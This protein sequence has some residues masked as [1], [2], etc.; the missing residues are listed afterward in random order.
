MKLLNLNTTDIAIV[1]A[2]VIL[3]FVMYG[4]PMVEKMTLINDDIDVKT[5]DTNTCSRSCCRHVQWKP[6]HMKEHKNDGFVGSN[7]MCNG[8]NGGGCVCITNEDKEYLTHRGNN[9][10]FSSN[11]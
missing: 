6:P 1:V 2:I 9:G 3:L 4:Y 8:G 7:Y 5:I 11:Q 10:K